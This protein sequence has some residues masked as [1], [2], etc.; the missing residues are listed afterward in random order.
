MSAHRRIWLVIAVALSTGQLCWAGTGDRPADEVKILAAID[1][2]FADPLSKEA[3]EAQ[4]QVV[5]FAKASPKVSVQVSPAFFQFTGSPYDA[6]LMAHYLAGAV[7]FDLE[8]PDQAN[9]PL[10]DVPAALRAALQAYRRLHVAKA[11]Y[12]NPFF[13]KVDFK[14]RGG[15]LDAMVKEIAAKQK[16]LQPQSPPQPSQQPPQPKP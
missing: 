8:H 5:A 11:V 16:Q 1:K 4:A 3:T 10:A 15:E 7:K 14:E 6:M 13:E 12:Y 2:M 9:D